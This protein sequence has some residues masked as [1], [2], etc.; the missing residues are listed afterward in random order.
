M[1]RPSD[2]HGPVAAR[3]CPRGA[4]VELPPQGLAAIRTAPSRS[5]R[6]S[7]SS[8]RSDGSGGATAGSTD[9]VPR[10]VRAALGA[11]GVRCRTGWVMARPSDPCGPSCG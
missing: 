7:N 10:P 8:L 2:L 5:G 6:T 11:L 1:V 3:L 9:A 4:G